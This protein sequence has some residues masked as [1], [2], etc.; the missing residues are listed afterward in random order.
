MTKPHYGKKKHHLCINTRRCIQP[1]ILV[2]WSGI[3]MLV[4]GCFWSQRS[5]DNLAQGAEKG[6]VEFIRTGDDTTAIKFKLVC[7][8]YDPN[9]YLGEPNLRYACTPGK[10]QFEISAGSYC[11]YITVIV[12]EGMITPLEIWVG[13]VG[14]SS[15]KTT[16]TRFSFDTHVTIKPLRAL[17]KEP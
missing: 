15:A 13:N 6:Y 16:S 7:L 2:L 1:G 10:H 14:K 12:A 9:K 3:I 11:E 5:I 17:N 4:A 8:D